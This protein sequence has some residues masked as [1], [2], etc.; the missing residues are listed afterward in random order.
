MMSEEL[1]PKFVDECMSKGP[2]SALEMRFIK[3][4]LYS[5]GYRLEELKKMPDEEM[6]ELMSEACKYASLKL[7]EFESRAQFREEIRAPSSF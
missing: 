4:Y 6:K 7:A 5:K 1:D 2:Q 3:E